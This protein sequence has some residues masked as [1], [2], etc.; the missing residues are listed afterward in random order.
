MLAILFLFAGLILLIAGGDGLVRG[1]VGLAERIHVPPLV[2]GLTI[3][4]IGTS[5][6]EMFVSVRAALNNAGGIAVGNVVGSNIANVLLVLGLPAMII[7]TSCKQKGLGK[8][9]IVMIGLAM[10]FMIMMAKGSLQRYDGVILLILT[11][12]FLYDQYSEARHHRRKRLDSDYHQEI[13]AVPQRRA[14]IAALLAFGILALPLGADLTVRGATEIATWLGLSQEVIGLTVI[15]I[16]TSLPE[17]ATALL[18]VWRGSSSVA[19]GNVVGSNIFNIG[20]IMGVTATIVPVGIASRVIHFDMWMMAGA[21]LLLAALAF[22]HLVI[23]RNR[24]L[25]MTGAYIIYICI[26]FWLN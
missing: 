8:N 15:A 1:A 14:V 17:L 19:L 20:A 18:A 10:V 25:A 21:I 2:I 3:V 9:L 13:G 4:A 7:A 11:C 12:W 23:T 22:Y 5:A 24:G 26:V 6:P 16:G